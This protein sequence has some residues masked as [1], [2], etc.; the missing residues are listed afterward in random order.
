MALTIKKHY[1]VL[2]MNDKQMYLCEDTSFTNDK[3]FALGIN[4]QSVAEIALDRINEVRVREKLTPP[5]TV[6]YE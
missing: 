3:R 4:S 5:C 6:V 2:N 1:I